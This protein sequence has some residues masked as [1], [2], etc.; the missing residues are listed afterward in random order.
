M[1]TLPTA[2]WLAIALIL[3]APAALAQGSPPPPPGA[4]RGHWELKSD[5]TDKAFVPDAVQLGDRGA[6]QLQDRAGAGT[7]GEGAF[8]GDTQ[9][10]GSS[11]AKTSAGQ[12][13]R[14]TGAAA[15]KSSGGIGFKLDS[16]LAFAAGGPDLFD[17]AGAKAWKLRR[18]GNDLA[19]MPYDAA[20]ALHRDKAVLVEGSKLVGTASGGR[21][22]VGSFRDGR[23]AGSFRNDLT[24][25]QSAEL[26]ARK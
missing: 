8:S 6:G 1:R 11:A 2:L 22:V 26:V 12:A 3:P 15:V 25:S 19:F 17:S 13:L 10:G 4:G 7:S 5:T 23:L 21:V 20:G 9:R 16:L 18:E 24:G 14:L